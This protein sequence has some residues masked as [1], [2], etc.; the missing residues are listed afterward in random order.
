MVNLLPSSPTI[1]LDTPWD[2]DYKA[3]ADLSAVHG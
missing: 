1:F 3:R 2:I